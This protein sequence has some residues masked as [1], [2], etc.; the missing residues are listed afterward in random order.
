MARTTRSRP[1]FREA[2]DER[3]ARARRFV[4][5]D[6]IVHVDAWRNGENVQAVGGRLVSVALPM[7]G[8]QADVVVVQVPGELD[9]RAYSLATIRS[10][11][12]RS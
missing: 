5:L 9:D 8:S 4:G 1:L 3:L 12:A 10:I 7:T 11:E 2:R 6:V